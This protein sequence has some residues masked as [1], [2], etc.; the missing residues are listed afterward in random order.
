[1]TS[2]AS[3]Y[4]NKKAHHFMTCRHDYK[5]A[6]QIGSVDYVCPLCKRVLDPMEWFLMNNFEFVDVALGAG[7]RPPKNYKKKKIL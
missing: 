7:Q 3:R 4:L 1:M 5:N 6:I 2:P